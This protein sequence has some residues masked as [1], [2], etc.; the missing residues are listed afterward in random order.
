VS[1]LLDERAGAIRTIDTTCPHCGAER[2]PDQAYCVECGHALPTVRGRTA[3][4]RRRWVRRFG[5]YPGDWVWISLLALLVAIAGA[6]AA[7]AVAHE[8]HAG[9][10][11]VITALGDV[12]VQQ[13][14]AASSLSTAAGTLPTPP[15]PTTTTARKHAKGDQ[16]WPAGETGW[17]IV[18]VS[19]PKTAGRPAART[20][21]DKAARSGLPEVGVLDSSR[22]ASLQPGYFV[23][24]SGI[25]DSQAQANAAVTSAHQAGFGAAYSRQIAG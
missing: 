13:P 3:G 20:T 14:V 11:H 4:L 16:V 22:Y 1:G 21:A 9:G 12:P 5:W 2:A 8:R 24:F 19:Y 23:V 10:P 25:Y 7:V 18:L 6:A 17:T 15:E